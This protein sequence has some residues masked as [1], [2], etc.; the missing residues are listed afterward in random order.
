MSFVFGLCDGC[1]HQRRVG[2]TR[3]STFSLCGLARTDDRFPKYP[4]MPVLRCA[5]FAL[6]PDERDGAGAGRDGATA[7]AGGA[8]TTGAPAAPGPSTGAS[9]GH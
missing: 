4:R 3:G 5:G 8:T 9:D 6:R 2:N 1:V 7:R